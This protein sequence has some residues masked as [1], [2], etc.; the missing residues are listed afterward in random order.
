MLCAGTAPDGGI[1]VSDGGIPACGGSCCSRACAPWGPTGVLVCQ[2]ATGCKIEGDLCTSSKECCGG[3]GSGTPG[4]GLVTCV[5][6]AGASV[7]ICRSPTGGSDAGHACIPNGDVCKLATASCNKNCD[8]C[9]G[10]CE[11]G[12]D[13][14]KQ[15][16]EGIPRCSLAQC[17]DGGASCASSADCCNGNPCVPGA[18]GHLT[19]FPSACVPSC[20]ACTTSADCCPGDNCLGGRCDPCGGGGNPDG[21]TT[22]GDGGPT[23]GGNP[24]DGGV[25]G[26]GGIPPLPDGGCAAYGQLCTSSPQC[27]NAIS[28]TGGRCVVITP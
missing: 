20:G 22:G 6:N 3:A 7:G 28:C 9:A 4:D 26:D 5:I 19:C 24:T 2:P 18:G 10:N 27:C 14:C 11:K 1:V 13:T 16:N 17:A 25:T 15:D 21:G 8:C 12:E 23:D